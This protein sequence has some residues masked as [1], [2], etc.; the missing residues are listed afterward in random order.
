M[1]R[2]EILRRFEAA[3][4]PVEKLVAHK[5][6]SFSLKESYFYRHG[7]TAEALVKQVMRLF[8]TASIIETRDDFRAWPTTSY[9]VAHFRILEPKQTEAIRAMDEC[10]G[11]ESIRNR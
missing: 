8:S 4:I 5:D 10:A 9:L 11:L 7:R 6:G 1:K 2:K 3:Q